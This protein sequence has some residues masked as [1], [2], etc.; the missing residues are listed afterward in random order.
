[1]SNLLVRFTDLSNPFFWRLDFSDRRVARRIHVHDLER[2]DVAPR[3]LAIPKDE[4]IFILQSTRCTE[5]VPHPRW[6][7]HYGDWNM[8]GSREHKKVVCNRGN[9]QSLFMCGQL[10]IGV[11]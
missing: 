8:G 11:R 3:Q 9:Q 2:M 10:G 7:L 4:Y 5:R 6:P 1:M